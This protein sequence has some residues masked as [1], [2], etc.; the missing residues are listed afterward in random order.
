MGFL[1]PSHGWGGEV[2][3]HGSKSVDYAL[4]EADINKFTTDINI[5][6][7]NKTFWCIPAR[8]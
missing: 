1:G 8:L 6:L 3:T 2:D 7:K 5:L 4:S